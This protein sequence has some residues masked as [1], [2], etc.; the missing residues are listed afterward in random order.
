MLFTRCPGC[1][2]TF[3]ISVDT[4]RVAH[5]AVRCGNCATVFSAFT[6]LRQDALEERPLEDDELLSPTLQMQELA[7]IEEIASPEVD[8]SASPID[9]AEPA[10]TDD[11]Q[12]VEPAA[13]DADATPGEPPELELEPEPEAEPEPEPVGD[14]APIVAEPDIDAPTPV[15]ATADAADE[16]ETRDEPVSTDGSSAK[17]RFEAPVDEWALLL[18]EI[19][20][21]VDEG[22][23]LSEDGADAARGAA[24]GPSS[25]TPSPAPDTDETPELWDIG[26]PFSLD[27]YDDTAERRKLGSLGP[28]ST[29][30]RE[31]ADLDDGDPE[32]AAG[33]D[34]AI[35]AEE[36]DA[37]LSAEPDPEIVAVLE[38][39]LDP[40]S[41]E[42]RSVRRW[43]L[44]S[45]ALSVAL[46]VQLV[47]H[48]RAP[49]ATQPGIGAA[50]QGVYG[51][52]GIELVP[53]WDLEQYEITNWA[54][55]AGPG[56]GGPGSLHITAQ[57]RNRGPQDQPY[58][59]IL[60]ELKDRW[61]AVIGSRVF[62]PSE[63]L[64]ASSR[65]DELMA[66][67]SIVPADLTV[68][69]PGLDASGFELDVCLES[70][71]GRM[72]CSSDRVFE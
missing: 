10:E 7:G 41:G 62:A 68:V 2:T 12:A 14:V 59:S 21:S 38:A 15:E 39:G 18:S 55:T 60:L 6:G 23:V 51:L 61:E 19:E 35:S 4:L 28:R 32:Y 31:T 64:A 9:D 30:A 13:G 56:R 44:G 8:A 43:A 70:D 40:T 69:D 57:I 16:P 1:Q 71:S 26:E 67:G 47:H 63:Y 66:A 34:Q 46:G 37:T 11:P 20:R 65:I 50:L 48:F 29:P 45:L 58:P 5:G 24:E 25:S 49:L 54:A 42:P 36:I 52:L 33:L 3:R 53:Q 27:A 72:S 17:L 22:S